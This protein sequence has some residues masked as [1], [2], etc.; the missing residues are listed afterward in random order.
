MV[1]LKRKEKVLFI[2]E[3]IIIYLNNIYDTRR[4]LKIHKLQITIET[5]MG[6][7]VFSTTFAAVI[8]NHNDMEEVKRRH[9]TTT[10]W[11]GIHQR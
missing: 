1:N 2:N 4:A 6:K 9:C 11:I 7:V 8:Q 10:V 5:E 3:I